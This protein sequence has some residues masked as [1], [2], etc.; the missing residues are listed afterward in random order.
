MALVASAPEKQGSDVISWILMPL[1]N[2]WRW[3]VLKPQFSDG[4]KKG[5]DFFLFT[6]F[7]VAGMKMTTSN[8][9][10]DSAEFVLEL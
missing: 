6:F 4:S 3:F 8:I 1:Q 10:Y 5:V 7:L 9:L 2:F